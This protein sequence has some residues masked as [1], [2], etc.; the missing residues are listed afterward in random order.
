[1]NIDYE[2]HENVC[3]KRGVLVCPLFLFL[4]VRIGAHEMV[5]VAISFDSGEIN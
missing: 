1:M 2:S 5:T 4:L 3:T